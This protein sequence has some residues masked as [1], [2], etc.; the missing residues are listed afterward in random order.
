MP[1]ITHTS[2]AT[3]NAIIVQPTS[4]AASR[5]IVFCHGGGYEYQ[6]PVDTGQHP[7]WTYVWESMY[8]L[9]ERGFAVVV[10][11]LI[12]TSLTYTSVTWP[13]P[14]QKG[15]CFGNDVSTSQLASVISA[16][17]TLVG[18]TGKYALFGHSLGNATI[19]NHFRRVADQSAIAG[20][21]TVVP[22]GTIELYRG[23]DASPSGG[24]S[25][26]S[27]YA[28]VNRAHG[29]GGVNGTTA[30]DAA[31]DAIKATKELTNIAPNVTVRWHAWTNSDDTTAPASAAVTLAGLIPSGKGTT[32]NRGT[33]GHTF[34]NLNGKDA[35]AFFDSL[36]W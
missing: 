19:F 16:A 7:E 21:L 8:Y 2:I 32:E 33:G 11:A 17:G 35:H 26:D 9:A 5:M 24:S 23:R 14:I 29:I 27:S 10:P 15:Y 31:W 13:A 36:S 30:C 18:A 28:T 1:L 6:Y 12:D 20:A 34:V 3:Q 4:R 22:V 25:A